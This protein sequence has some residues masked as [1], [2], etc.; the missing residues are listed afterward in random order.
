MAMKSMQVQHYKFGKYLN[1]EFIVQGF[2]KE[3]M[4]DLFFYKNKKFG[5]SLTRKEWKIYFLEK[6]KKLAEHLKVQIV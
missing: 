5:N 3:T 4:E 2:L 1:K 6:H